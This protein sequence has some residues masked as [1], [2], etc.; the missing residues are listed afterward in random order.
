MSWL[1]STA[2]F[3]LVFAQLSSKHATT[4]ALVLTMLRERGLSSPTAFYPNLT[5]ICAG[6]D[7]DFH[8]GF[9]DR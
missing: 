8:D 5:L 3:R 2:V 4:D 1:L 7:V 9:M 6:G